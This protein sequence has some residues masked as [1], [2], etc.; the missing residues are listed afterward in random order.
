MDV[1]VQLCAAVQGIVD[2]WEEEGGEEGGEDGLRRLVEN[3]GED[4]FVDMMGERGEVE[5]FGRGSDKRGEG[6]EGRK[7]GVEHF[8]WLYSK[9]GLM[10]S[11]CYCKGILVRV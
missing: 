8:G 10:E 11:C 9:K 5:I 7:E 4:D 2:A 3:E 1:P 6:G